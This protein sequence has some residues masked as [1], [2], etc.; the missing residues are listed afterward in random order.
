VSC[1]KIGGDQYDIDEDTGEKNEPMEKCFLRA[2]TPYY[3]GVNSSDSNINAADYGYYAP[4]N[5]DTAPKEFEEMV[6]LYDLKSEKIVK[7]NI[8]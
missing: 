7:W 8:A 6:K 2:D 1:I 3:M 5:R 4:Y